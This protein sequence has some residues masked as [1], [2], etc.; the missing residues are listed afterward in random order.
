MSE[1]KNITFEKRGAVCFIT[2]N[3]PEKLNALDRATL[4][5]LGEAFD[6]AERDDALHAVVVTG[7]GPKAFAAG[8]DI[9]EIAGLGA[10][11]GKAFALYGQGFFRRIE[12]FLKPVVAAVNGFALGGGC[13]LAMAC[14]IRLASETAWFG[15]PEINLGIIPGYGGTQR[16]SRLAGRAAALE[17]LLTGD[18]IPAARAREIGL[19]NAVFPQD[20]LMG[21]AAALAEKLAAKAPL[22]AAY[23]IEAVAYGS[24]MPLEEACYYEA[25]L[26][27]LACATEDKKEGTAAFLEK[28]AASF[29]G[30]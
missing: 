3:R 5:E 4:K 29:K 7:A 8:A 14:H 26:F 28:R 10:E 6:E 11:A 12:R 23:C 1:F 25:T 22:A 13:E 24:D 21:E 18:R 30:R 27:G 17:M 15:Q 16:L 2:L 19:V 20:K 9:T